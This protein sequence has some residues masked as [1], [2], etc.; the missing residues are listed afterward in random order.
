MNI[1]TGQP[2][3]RTEWV[4]WF[5]N[6]RCRPAQIARKTTEE[7]AQA[8]IRA[9]ADAGQAMRVVGAGHSLTPVVVTDGVLMELAISSDV[10]VD[11]SRLTARISAGQTVDEVARA[12]W[13]KGYSPINVGELTTATLIGAISTGVH[14][15][16]LGLGCLA[17]SVRAARVVTAT[18]LVEEITEETPERLNAVQISLGMLGVITEMTIDVQPAVHLH[19]RSFFC[20]PEVLAEQWDSLAEEN[21]HFSFFYLPDATK[22]TDHAY[23]VP[24][25]MAVLNAKGPALQDVPAS[26]DACLVSLRNSVDPGAA[27]PL[28]PG[29]R[30]GPMHDI[31]TYP[32]EEPY[33]EIEMGVDFE[34]GAQTFLE[35]RGRVQTRHAQ[36]KH[37]MLVRCAARDRALLSW[38]HD[39]PKAIFSVVDDP[40]AAYETVLADFEAFF[41][42]LGALPH[43]GKE[44]RLTPGRLARLQPNLDAFRAIRRR[45]DPDGLFLNDHLRQLFV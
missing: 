22:I 39:G 8:C 44:H 25:I 28:G 45:M 17:S 12:L 15:T 18:G 31:L 33:R 27:P 38:F 32:F 36:Y 13:S 2:A 24:Q 34:I 37:P 1:V 10:P 23:V 16:G 30:L 41:D 5:G 11:P 40:D 29:E 4:N 20:T 19:E 9:A 26:G 21:R 14:G 43:W 3:S 35:M 6:Q 42:G 7:A